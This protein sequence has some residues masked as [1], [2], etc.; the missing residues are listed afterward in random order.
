MFKLSDQPEIEPAKA[1]DRELY[2]QGQPN[3]LDKV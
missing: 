2:K 1:A 3:A